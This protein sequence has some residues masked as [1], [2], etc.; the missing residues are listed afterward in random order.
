MDADILKQMSPCT[1]EYVG[2]IDGKHVYVDKKCHFWDAMVG[3]CMKAA[4]VNC[5]NGVRLPQQEVVE[6]DY[7]ILG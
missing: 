5:P 3:R 2:K 1:K 4:S 6:M 7:C